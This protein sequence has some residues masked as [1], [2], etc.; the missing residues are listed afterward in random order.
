MLFFHGTGKLRGVGGY[1]S[2]CVRLAILI[3]G[4][5]LLI[6][7]GLVSEARGAGFRI[8]EFMAANAS[9][10]KDEDGDYSDWIEIQNEDRVGRSLL[11]WALSD[12]SK[13][14][15][16]WVFSEAVVP[17]GGF[18]L[19][20]ASGKNRLAPKGQ[21][22]AN[23]KLNRDGGFLALTSPDGHVASRFAPY[24]RQISDVSY[25]V[26]IAIQSVTWLSA[27]DPGRLH[28]PLN[29]SFAQV[30]MNPAFD[31]SDWIRAT[32]GV[33]Y[34]RIPPGQL[35]PLEPPRP[36]EDLTAPGDPAIATSRN[37]PDSEGVG[38]AIDNNPATKYLNF[39]KLNVGLTV[40]AS[41]GSGVVTGLRFTS[42]NDS[43]ERDP[44][45]FVLYGSN[46]GRTFDVVSQGGIPAFSGRF[47]PVQV[48]FANAAAYSRYRLLF[49]TVRNAAAAAAMQ[50]AEVEFLGKTGPEPQP[51][52]DWIRTNVESP[53][54]SGLKTTAYLRFP[55]VVPE[56]ASW[57]EL[58]LLVRFD[59]GFAA[60]VNGVPVARG[61]APADLGFNGTA[62]TNRWRRDVMQPIRFDF[63]TKATVLHPGTNLLAL[64]GWNDRADSPDFLLE[65]R[66]E[67]TRHLVGPA[68]YCDL[69]TPRAVNASVKLGLV[70]DPVP[71]YSHGFHETPFELTL[72]CATDG[73][74][75]RYTTD[76][77][78][79]GLTN[80]LPYRNAIRIDRTTVLRV[81]AFKEGWRTSR[82]LTRTYVFPGEVARQSR[83]QALAAGFPAS[84]GSQ[85][86]DYGL[87]TRVVGPVDNF[88]GKYS[89][90]FSNDLKS[91]PTM[92]IAISTADMFGPQ[93]IY[94]NPHSHGEAWER[95][96]SIELF[97]PDNRVGFQEE[98][99]LR[100]QGGAFRG[101]NLTLKKSFRV[102]FRNKYGP[103]TLLFPL[104]GSEAAKEINNFV[105]RANSNDAWPYGGGSSLYVRDAFAMESA[106]AMS[107]PASHSFFV[108]LYI[109]GQYWGL[110]NP[111]ERP[112]A[113]FCA[114]YYGGNKE[115]WDAINQDSVPDGTYDAWNRM[116]A[117]L[118]QD[119][120]RAD[121]YQRIQGNN[122]DGSRNPAYECLL[123][124]DNMIDYLILNFYIGNTDWP[125]RNWWSG[126]DRKNGDGFKFHP[127]DSETALGFSG[128]DANV[129]GVGDAVAR[130]Y[131]ALRANA[132]FRLRFADHV[133]RHFFHGGAFHVASSDPWDPVKPQN[134]RPAARFF[135]LTEQI[136][137]AIVGESA[138]WGDQ[139]RSSPFTRD[140]HWLAARNSLLAS[141]FP[142]RSQ[143]VLQQLRS[144]RLYPSIDPPEMNVRGGVVEPGFLLSLSAPKG[145]IYYTTD[146]ADPRNP[147]SRR[148]YTAPIVL[149]DL[150][151]VKARVLN[152]P[153]WSALNRASF[154]VGKPALGVS[155]IHYHPAEPTPAERSAG[156][157][158]ADDFEFLE[159]VNHGA[160]TYDLRAVRFETGIQ[161]EF[162]GSAISKLAPGGY[163]LLVR[164]RAAFES[165]YGKE[166]PIAGQYSGKLDNNGERIQALNAAGE[167]IIDFMF[168]VRSP[169]P[170]APDGSGPSLETINPADSLDAAGNWRASDQS[171]GSP[172][173]PKPVGPL[174]LEIL[175][176]GPSEIRISFE[177]RQGSTYTLYSNDSV[178]F[179]SWSL[180]ERGA[181]LSS[182]SQVELSLTPATDG[183]ARFFRISIP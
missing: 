113:A 65:A 183:L 11:G 7:A 104:F 165:R 29:N 103:G 105:L 175:R 5:V 1:G 80:G 87:D 35:D 156:F 33:G 63:A 121:V 119:F 173:K 172:G 70:S 9:G 137:R 110:Y 12:D 55:F 120:S 178:P 151:E 134:N 144:A 133:Y 167:V 94:S 40:S 47:T 162:T 45:S 69:A 16:K 85:P 98:A 166:L 64:Q 179:R 86:A 19:V 146:G 180:V 132:E 126:R 10:V 127:W 71:N 20:F 96:I 131:A 182:D 27:K 79:P 17:P 141:Y 160:A 2:S 163:L 39:D 36:M 4:M 136:N 38:N 83:S 52:S 135:A 15:R 125:G 145:S 88:G 26:S 130:P 50:I 108:H 100:I 54:F 148:L 41:K 60:W 62:P 129:T 3:P 90:T 122:P 153:E 91:V 116:L 28:V 66:I 68:G 48:S 77:S 73:A 149:S 128:L 99:G 95:P 174:R 143:I 25:G 93:G 92:S 8:T 106:R 150:T 78:A 169:W 23:F 115:D 84:W 61:N 124:V 81:A 42:A 111:A 142:R 155:E 109:N 75:M 114:S 117:M 82:V 14:P 46:N 51:V 56:S 176:A 177:G 30:W 76:G 67:S 49:P 97:Y 32:N 18:S 139:L 157:I 101:F 161:F 24:P 152:G 59:D 57:D 44:T 37:S 102:V 168:G 138:R 107:I 13:A 154:V 58:A 112:D 118:N 140:E 72:T 158:D 159:L 164:N 34:D 31:D 181:A 53:L 170:E 21:W 43:P 22:H 74:G 147:A 89:R 171:G 6:F 123:D